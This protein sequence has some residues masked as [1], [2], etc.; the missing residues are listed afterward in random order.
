[1]STYC[2][3]ICTKIGFCMFCQKV[4][5]LEL[6]AKW[7]KS[8]E[9]MWFCM[10]RTWCHDVCLFF[11]GKLLCM[12]GESSYPMPKQALNWWPQTS[13]LT[14][15]ALKSPLRQTLCIQILE[16]FKTSGL[17]LT[18]I[19]GLIYVLAMLTHFKNNSCSWIVKNNNASFH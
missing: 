10:S 6:L 8:R 9:L 16:K 5:E 11:S 18:T 12:H 17:F 15:W 3:W 1:M 19:Y 7:P 13:T 2:L 4:D 14:H